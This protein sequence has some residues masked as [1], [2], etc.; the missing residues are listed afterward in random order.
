MNLQRGCHILVATPGRL[1]DLVNR[2]RLSFDHVRFVVLD[3]ADR[4][5]D[6]GFLSDIEKMMSHPSM[7]VTVSIIMKYQN[8]C[9]YVCVE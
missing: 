8:C 4:M 2:G 9:T 7:P 1:H 3:E 5:L 6:M